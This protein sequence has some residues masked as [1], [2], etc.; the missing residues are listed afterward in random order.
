[1]AGP[2]EV[3]GSL[4]GSLFSGG[5]RDR[6]RRLLEE[7]RRLYEGLETDLEAPAENVVGLGPSAYEQVAEDPALRRSQLATLARLQ[8]LADSDGLDA[9]ARSQLA[10]AQ[11]SNAGLERA[12]RG[13]IL[14]TFARRGMGNSNSALLAALSSQQGAAQRAGMEGLS[15][16]GN[17]QLRALQ[18]LRDSGD[19]AG[20]L[21][22]QDY[23]VASNLAGARD[24]VSQ[25]N[26]A[27]RQAVLGRN[28]D[29]SQRTAEGNR[30]ARFRRVAG[31]T[32]ANTDMTDFHRQQEA[33]RR[34]LWTGLGQGVGS[35]VEAGMGFAG[36]FP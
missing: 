21:R 5:D 8:E 3:Y 20:N 28:T 18:A 13:A 12:Q 27:N 30:D 29:R 23:G 22:S 26:A 31:M 1:M 32:G 14:D 15:A 36:G 2:F 24:R 9:A 34:G 35:A 10:E 7:N 4:L 16:A 17:A 11:A 33:R 25:Y 19:L 6:Q